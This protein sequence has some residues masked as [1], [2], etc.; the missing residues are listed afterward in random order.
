METF[1]AMKN[2]S[3]LK[4]VKGDDSNQLYYTYDENINLYSS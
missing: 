1:N 4:F 3:Q 2:N